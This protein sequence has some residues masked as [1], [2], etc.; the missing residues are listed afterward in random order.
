MA[1]ATVLSQW[2]AETADKACIRA[3]RRFDGELEARYTDYFE[4]HQEQRDPKQRFSAVR[5]ELTLPPGH[6]GLLAKVEGSL[7]NRHRSGKS[8]QTLALA[9]L[10]V[11]EDQDPSLQWLFQA[12]D[13]PRPQDPE[14]KGRIEVDL[15]RA[16]LSEQGPQTTAVDY[17]VEDSSALI[18]LEAKWNEQGL[19]R[20]SCAKKGGNPAQGQC[21]PLVRTRDLYWEAGE[22]LLGLAHEPEIGAPCPI[23]LGYQAVRN[24]A[25]ARALA[26][27]GQQPVFAL[28]YNADNPFFVET[29]EWAGW[30]ALLQQTMEAAAGA[31]EVLFRSLSWQ[32]LIGHLPLDQATRDWAR[33]KHGL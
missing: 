31:G 32:Q 9:L 27:P 29:D 10:G 5:S 18:C 33:E 1:N 25:A 22:R 15:D 8:S 7:H 30:P 3:W 11:A 21:S 4:A 20:C 13:L 19:G 26:K 23:S 14:P 24:I 28:I 12:L 17:L 16:L 2:S 6:E